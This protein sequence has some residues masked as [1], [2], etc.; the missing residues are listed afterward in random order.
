M[1]ISDYRKEARTF[2]KYG[3]EILCIC[4]AASG[5]AGVVFISESSLVC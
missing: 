1:N 5:K 4:V 3:Q 2:S